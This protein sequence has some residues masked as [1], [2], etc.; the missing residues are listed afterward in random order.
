MCK[1][2]CGHV[3]LCL[4]NMFLEVKLLG[5]L[6]KFCVV[7]D[8]MPA[9]SA[10]MLHHLA[11]PPAMWE[12]SSLLRTLVKHLLTAIPPIPLGVKWYL[13]AAFIPSSLLTDVLR[14]YSRV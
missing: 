13:I 5:H 12:G 8:G 1:F 9:C 7:F 6:V 10:K 14:I 4:F 11:S 2:L 3:L